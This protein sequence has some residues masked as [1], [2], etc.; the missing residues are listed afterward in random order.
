MVHWLASLC[1][2]ALLLTSPLGVAFR[3]TQ[4]SA[5]DSY[6]A[7]SNPVLSEPASF[8][9]QAAGTALEMVGQIGGSVTAMTVDGDIVY[10]GA[11]PRLVILSM[12]DPAHPSLLGQT[13]VLPSMVQS[14]VVSERFVYIAT[15]FDGLRVI[16]VINPTAPMEV[17]SFIKPGAWFKDVAMVGHY[18]Y[19]VTSAGLSVIDVTNPIAPVEIGSCAIPGPDGGQAVAA[20]GQTVYVASLRGG[21]RVIDVTNPGAPVEVG[22]YQT[23]EWAADVAVTG[24]YSYVAT[25]TGRGLQVIDVA[26]PA[27]PVEVGSFAPPGY[28]FHVAAAGDYAYVVGD[29]GLSVISVA[30]P[31]MPVMVGVLGTYNTAT[32]VDVAG[33]YAFV[34]DSSGLRVIQVPATAFAVGSSPPVEVGHYVAPGGTAAHMAMAGHHAYTVDY[35]DRFRV[36]DLTNPAVPIEVSSLAD[37]WRTSDVE[38]VGDYAYLAAS[39]P[40]MQIIDVTNPA[41]PVEVGHCLDQGYPYGVTVSDNYAYVVD[42]YGVRVIDVTDRQNPTEIGNVNLPWMADD[43]ISRS[44]VVAG[45]YAYVAEAA[46]HWRTRLYGGLWIVD[47]ANPAAPVQVGFYN[48]GTAGWGVAMAGSYAYVAYESGLRVIDVSI[49]SAPASAGTLALSGARSIAVEGLHAYITTGGGV[50]MIGVRNPAA[51]IEI[52]YYP[53]PGWATDVAVADGYVYVADGSG[54]LYV[55]RRDEPS[56]PWRLWLPVILRP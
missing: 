8:Q 51:M 49:P 47:V 1:V 44:I 18:I 26:N 19:A 37:I 29:Y 20:A 40:G 7:L 15:G 2:F 50:R 6:K 30:N 34:A 33:G 48:L 36:I 56:D 45:G 14:L 31:T 43:E 32:D 10:A 11:G 13:D 21:L 25:S 52:D 55:L 22:F 28:A 24:S 4:I 38:A 53:M 17:G 54:G 12:A 35:K 46:S 42:G 16:D 9:P 5:L 39:Y 27:T 41:A 3:S 23:S